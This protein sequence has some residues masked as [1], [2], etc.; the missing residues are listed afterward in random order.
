MKKIS[1][2]RNSHNLVQKSSDKLMGKKKL[3]FIDRRRQK[4]SLCFLY[5]SPYFKGIQ[6]QKSLGSSEP[7]EKRVNY[8]EE[9]S[10]YGT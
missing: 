2:Y 4:N 7:H 10:P 8:M 1:F 3:Y 5:I 6:S 9:K